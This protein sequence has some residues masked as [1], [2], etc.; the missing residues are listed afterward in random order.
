MALKVP[1]V[2]LK[3]VAV[4]P[5]PSVAVPLVLLTVRVGY[6]TPFNEIT[7][8]APVPLKV[9]VLPVST[10]FPDVNDAALVS[11]PAIPTVPLIV[12]LPARVPENVKL[13]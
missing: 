4:T 1:A 6:V 12:M 7:V 8:C 3:A 11:V 13:L 2:I 10:K 9:K 5:L